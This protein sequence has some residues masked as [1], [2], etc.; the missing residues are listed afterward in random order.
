MIRVVCLDGELDV[1]RVSSFGYGWPIVDV[2]AVFYR[3]IKCRVEVIEASL[4]ASDF[5]GQFTTDTEVAKALEATTIIEGNKWDLIIYV[6]I[7]R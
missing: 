2:A 1:T 5:N 4:S 6:D 3:V 7:L